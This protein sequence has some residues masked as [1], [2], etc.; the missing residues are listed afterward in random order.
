MSKTLSR[1]LDRPEKEM[2]SLISKLED[3]CGYPS[4]DVRLLAENAHRSRLKI[5][6]LGLDP[7]DTTAEELYFAL[8]ARFERDSRQL[9]RALAADGRTSL[10]QRL[11]LAAQLLTRGQSL[12]ESWFLKPSAAKALLHAQPLKKIMRHL[13]YRSA[14]S[15]L[16]KE[17][18]AELQLA[19]PYLESKSW[20]ADFQR[21]LVKVDSA[22]FEM[23]R[24][25]V[26]SLSAAKWVGVPGP[27][28]HLAIDRLL[29]STTV[30]PTNLPPNTPVLTIALQLIRGLEILSSA[31][32][33]AALY[34]IHPALCW[35]ADTDHLLTNY[36]EQPV[37]LNIRDIAVNHFNGRQFNR[38]SNHNGAKSLIAELMRRYQRHSAQVAEVAGDLGYNLSQQIDQAKLPDGRQL[39]TELVA[40]E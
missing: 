13:N 16:K 31:D 3:L 29:G 33:A 6:Q 36:E 11:A 18:I 7:D 14:E 20:Q 25:Q 35:W 37:S 4:E 10:D 24:P 28:N 2:A 15:L 22:G 30:W 1:L 34:H 5:Q 17:N 39:A 23:R 8:L 38:R 19:V 21:K 40:A 32:A 26:L 27:K 9:D 12:P